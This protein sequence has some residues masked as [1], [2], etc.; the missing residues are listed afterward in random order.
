M[1]RP[2]MPCC[3]PYKRPCTTTLTDICDHGHRQPASSLYL[4]V[5]VCMCVYVCLLSHIWPLELL[6]VKKILS[7]TQ[8]ETKVK[9][10][11]VKPLRCREPPPF[12]VQSAIKAH[13]LTS[14]RCGRGGGWTR[15]R[16]STN[17]IV[18]LTKQNVARGETSPKRRLLYP[19]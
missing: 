8:R 12:Y 17:V 9:K 5:C 2:E 1:T 18:Q 19:L 3:V 11:C 16:A 4:C 10:L 13:A 6:F 7:R 15:S 14:E